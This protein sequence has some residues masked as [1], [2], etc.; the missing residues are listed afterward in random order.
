[1]K[2]GRNQ[3]AMGGAYTMHGTDEKINIRTLPQKCERKITF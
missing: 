3:D 1:V 2:G